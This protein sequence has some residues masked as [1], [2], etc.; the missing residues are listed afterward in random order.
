MW[1][2]ISRIAIHTLAWFGFAALYYIVMS[3][4]FYTPYEY[5][6]K[7]TTSTLTNQYRVLQGRYDSLQMVLRNI[8]DRDASVFEMIFESSP[9]SIN[10]QRQDLDRYESLLNKSID[11]LQAELDQRT[12]QL[13]VKSH[14]LVASTVT[15]VESVARD[16]KT[17]RRIP[18]IQPINNPDLVLLTAG[19]GTKID[20]FYKIPQHHTGVDYTIAEGTRVF[21]TAD[22]V[23]EST[24]LNSSVLGKSIVVDHGNGYKTTYSHLTRIFIPQRRSVKR[25]EIIGLSGNTGLSITPHLHYEVSFN[26][27]TV[28]PVNYFFMELTPERYQQ[29]IDISHMGM[30]SFD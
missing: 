22:G 9:R 25:G 4:F 7:V 5:T 21:A 23:V 14:D 19:Y 27:Q 10:S 2:K 3:L 6:L 17:N 29:L 11:E 20:P 1:Q 18:A 8:E 15:M 16:S 30:Q 28:D 12:S 26:G 13:S 24:Q